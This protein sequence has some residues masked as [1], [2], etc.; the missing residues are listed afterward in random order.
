MEVSGKSANLSTLKDI[1]E[2]LCE[3]CKEENISRAAGGICKQCEEYMCC[4]CFKN[5]HAARS[6]RKHEFID[7]KGLQ[8][9]VPNV[10]DNDHCEVCSKHKSEI[11]KYYCRRHDDVACGE[12]MLL[13]EHKGCSPELIR[14]LANNFQKNDEFKGLTERIDNLKTRTGFTTNLIKLATEKNSKINEDALTD[15]K[16]FMNDIR[17]VINET[18]QDLLSKVSEIYLQNE[19]TLSSMARIYE[20]TETKL[21][22]VKR[23]INPLICSENA[24][25]IKM[26][27]YK[28]TLVGIENICSETLKNTTVNRFELRKDDILL[29]KLKSSGS[30]GTIS[31][32]VQQIFGNQDSGSGFNNEHGDD[33]NRFNAAAHEDMLPMVRRECRL[34]NL[35][36]L[37]NGPKQLGAR[38]DDTSRLDIS[39][40]RCADAKEKR[41]SQEATKSGPE[42]VADDVLYSIIEKERL[43]ASECSDM[44]S[45][46]IDTVIC[47]DTST[48]MA[49]KPLTAAIDCIEKILDGFETNAIYHGLGENVAIVTFGN[50]NRIRHHLTNDYGLI[51]EGLDNIEAGGPSPLWLGL[52][53]SLAEIKERG[54]ACIMEP[55]SVL[56]RIILITDGYASRKNLLNGDDNGVVDKKVIGEIV[57]LMNTCP[58]FTSYLECII[59][60]KCHEEFLKGLTNGRMYTSDDT[61][62]ITDFF[63]IQ[64]K[65]NTIIK[66]V[67]SAEMD[68]AK[69]DDAIENCELN[70]KGKEDLRQIISASFPSNDQQPAKME[71]D[72][73]SKDARATSTATDKSE[74]AER[75]M[76]DRD[77]QL[78]SVPPESIDLSDDVKSSPFGSAVVSNPKWICHATRQNFTGTVVGPRRK[79]LLKVLWSDGSIVKCKFG[80]N[81]QYDILMSEDQSIDCSKLKIGSIVVRGKDWRWKDQDGGEGNVGVVTKIDGP[82]VHVIWSHGGPGNYRYGFN[83]KFDLTLCKYRSGMHFAWHITDAEDGEQWKR[84]PKNVNDSIEEMYKT[85]HTG[86][87]CVLMDTQS[88]RISIQN[89]QARNTNT[90]TAYNLERREMSNEEWLAVNNEQ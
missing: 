28:R 5:H 46:G 64:E 25:F 59:P 70:D 77:G 39:A 61:E 2:T 89:L 4:I 36:L 37:K 68:R 19:E 50:E 60:G 43:S 71:T 86:T 65:A 58:S 73:T 83:K 33:D 78:D 49:G 66:Q 53:L 75:P 82:V 26:V 62:S 6:C 22:S 8:I 34:S 63:K 72:G 9:E 3:P 10:G 84:L 57:S 18:E 69:I 13:G 88:L 38:G 15:I 87:F 55:M 41:K 14:C 42:L 51:R 16:M 20:S 79:G 54:G 80:I 45:T 67:I 35:K 40:K 12:C 81:G 27:K 47:L 23:D 32:V 30:F 31:S 52:A 90:Q 29:N 56:P 7:S 21:E 74:H 44:K 48:S 17:E 76:T 24:L 1:K 11:I 85:K